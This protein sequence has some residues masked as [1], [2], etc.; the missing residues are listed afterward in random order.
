MP[1]PITPIHGHQ[2]NLRPRKNMTTYTPPPTKTNKTS[3]QRAS[4]DKVSNICLKETIE[5]I[6][7]K[8]EHGKLSKSRNSGCALCHQANSS[9]CKENLEKFSQTNQSDD[10]EQSSLS[11]DQLMATEEHKQTNG[12]IVFKMTSFHSGKNAK[13]SARLST[14]MGKAMNVFSRIEE[15]DRRDLRF[16]L[17]GVRIH[18]EQTVVSA[19][20]ENLDEIDVFH[21]QPCWCKLCSKPIL[22]PEIKIEQPKPVVHKTSTIKHRQ[23]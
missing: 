16:L 13:F 7:V 21:G 20:L 9:E 19:E 11:R 3:L 6:E 4:L 23:T 22:E 15:M 10:I 17:N 14:K 12:G 18:Q 5:L 2:Y 8:C 1:C